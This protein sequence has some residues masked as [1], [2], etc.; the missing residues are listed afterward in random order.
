MQPRRRRHR[1]TGAA[2]L[3]VRQLEVGHA[4]D[5]LCAHGAGHGLDA[6]PA[7]W[8]AASAQPVA[9][10]PRG[11]ALRLRRRRQSGGPRPA[12]LG[13]AHRRPPDVRRALVGAHCLHGG[14]RARGHHVSAHGSDD[15]PGD[16]GLA[17]RIAAFQPPPP[18]PLGGSGAGSGRPAGQRSGAVE[19]P[20]GPAAAL[21]Q[22]RDPHGF[23]DG[24]C[25]VPSELRLPGRSRS[26][27]TDGGAR[28]Q[29]GTGTARQGPHGPARSRPT[30]NWKRSATRSRTICARRC[31]ASTGGAWRCGRTAATSST[32]RGAST[33][34]ACVPI[35]SGWGN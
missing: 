32:K 26:R 3:G 10:Q 29:C 31:A 19:L 11:P 17:A 12:R 23:A 16:F 35:R 18:E 30:G 9:G 5:C 2:E 4:G 6:D 25:A 20:G 14:R 33:F 22:P 27:T 28:A 21:R 8:R 15:F 34:S 1:A 7:Q 24:G 13:A